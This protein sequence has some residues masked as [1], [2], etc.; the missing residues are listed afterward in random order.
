MKVTWPILPSMLRAPKTLI[1]SSCSSI[2]LT[3]F[4]F[5]QK[6]TFTLSG[7]LQERSWRPL[8]MKTKL[9]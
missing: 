9:S 6:Y 8:E 5:V 3:N 4:Y 2:S 1:H 7:Q